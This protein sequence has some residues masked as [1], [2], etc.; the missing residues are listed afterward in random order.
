MCFRG[1]S[2]HVLALLCV[3][4]LK[5]F[6]YGEVKWIESLGHLLMKKPQSKLTHYYFIKRTR[7]CVTT[8]TT[9]LKKQGSVPQ[10][11]LAIYIKKDFKAKKEL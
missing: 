4:R 2:L 7:K 5:P 9:S 11:G 8:T 3:W 1:F 6:L 10:C